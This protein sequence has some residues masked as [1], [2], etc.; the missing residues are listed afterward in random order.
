MKFNIENYENMTAEQKVAAL[1][2]YEPDMTGFVAK[3]VF[4]K[5]ASEAAELSKQLKAK[6]TEEEAK[7][8]AEAES[9]AKLEARVKELETEK[10][11]NTYV[12]S[13]LAMGYDEKL[14]K[15][16]A[17]AMVDGDMATV[18]A[19]QKTHIENEKKALKA[20]LLKET[21][22][23]SMTGEGN[24]G[25]TLDS[26]KKMSAQERLDFYSKN[27]EQYKALYDGGNK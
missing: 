16:T 2:A 26:L 24:S 1:E 27:P 9:R 15:S 7:A 6:M 18:F 23:P 11:L 3:S 4:D 8:A 14:A 13:Y 21:P 10:T 25:V 17:Q 5:K 12:N 22:T 20:D 19:N